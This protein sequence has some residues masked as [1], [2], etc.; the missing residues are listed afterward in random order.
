MSINPTL[1]STATITTN[2]TT[3]SDNT[4]DSN[5]EQFN[6]N[7]SVDQLFHNAPQKYEKGDETYFVIETISR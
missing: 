3:D 6:G 4:I 7:V 1:T 5:T 2:N